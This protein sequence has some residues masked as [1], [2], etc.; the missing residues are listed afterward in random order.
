MTGLLVFAAAVGIV[1]AGVFLVVTRWTG[2]R[3]SPYTYDVSKFTAATNAPG[4][5]LATRLKLDNK[6]PAAIAVDTNG[7]MFVAGELLETFSP[8]GTQVA[9]WPLPAQATCLAVAPNGNFFVGMTEHVVVLD[10]TGGLKQAW[11]SRGTNAIFTSIALCGTDVY[12]ADAGNHVVLRYSVN[13]VVECEIGRKDTARGIPGFVIPS[14]YFDIAIG[15]DNSLWVANPGMHQLEDYSRDGELR[16][17][18][19]RVGI[20]V[21]GF[22]GCCNPAHFALVQN[23]CFVTAEKAVPRVKISSPTGDF[24]CLV[25]GPDAFSEDAV[26]LDLAVDPGQRILVLDP[27]ERF[28]RIY[29]PHPAP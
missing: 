28:L 19:R 16:T 18:W 6:R 3:T 2:N 13:G 26:G 24:I 8:E 14:A 7:T 12:V 23:G 17:S 29:E 22:C 11:A 20:G 21:D 10:P 4:Y 15:L 9:S 1:V 25:A 5:F 27:A